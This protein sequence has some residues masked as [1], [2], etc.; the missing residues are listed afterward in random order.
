MQIFIWRHSLRSAAA[1]RS[2]SITDGI[3]RQAKVK[4]YFTP[5]ME[6]GNVCDRI[7]KN[8]AEAPAPTALDKFAYKD[9]DRHLLK[10]QDSHQKRSIYLFP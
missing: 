2:R 5:E 3:M 10:F 4:F 1:Q 6:S 7:L 8:G 9:T